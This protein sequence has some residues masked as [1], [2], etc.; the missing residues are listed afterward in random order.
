M[1]SVVAAVVLFSFTTFAA[2]P[3]IPMPPPLLPLTS[4]QATPAL[5]AEPLALSKQWWWYAIWG[6]A[7]LQTVAAVIL[8]GA[9]MIPRMA[10][11]PVGSGAPR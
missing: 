9:I 5:V 3:Y 10:P 2:E 1:K 8:F 6:T 11:Q 7:A 4:E